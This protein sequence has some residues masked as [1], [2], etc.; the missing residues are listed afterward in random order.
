M[1]SL[2]RTTPQHLPSRLGSARFLLSACIGQHIGDRREQQDR[3]GVFTSRRASGCALAVVADGMGGRTGGALAAEQVLSTSRTLFDDFN[4]AHQSVPDLLAE[5]IREAHTVI[6]LTG[7]TAEKEPHSTFAAMVIQPDL[8]S[9]AHVGDSRLYYF[10]GSKLEFR[11]TD[12]SYVEH[13]IRIGKL[14][15][16]GAAHHRMGH[17]LTSALGTEKP[18]VIDFGETRDIAAGD[19]F[20]LCTDGLWHYF[21]DEELGQM[22]TAGSAREAS[23]SLIEHARYRARGKGDN[24]TFAIVK[25]L[26]NDAA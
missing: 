24:C 26:E 16:E 18:P 23:E 20:L 21:S 4:P 12:H 5:I 25:L 19:S 1:P 6:Q 9:W 8:V 14:D 10:K 22:V 17:V 2:R 13:L 11:T 3:A 15:R 7:A